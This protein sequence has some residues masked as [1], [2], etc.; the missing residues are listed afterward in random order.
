MHVTSY[1][2]LPRESGTNANDCAVSKYPVILPPSVELSPP[3]PECACGPELESGLGRGA[4]SDLTAEPCC[5]PCC[6]QTRRLALLPLPSAQGPLDCWGGKHSTPAQ[7][8]QT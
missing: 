5:W 3:A 8:G 6:L 1:W 4:R 7:P 2:A